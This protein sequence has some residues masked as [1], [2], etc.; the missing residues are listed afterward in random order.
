MKIRILL[1]SLLTLIVIVV[2]SALLIPGLALKM[3]INYPKFTHEKILSDSSM[4][5]DYGIGN[6]SAPEDYG[7]SAEE[8]DFFSMDSTALNGWYIEASQPGK[9]C[10]VLI[11]GRTSNR[12]KTMKFL[13]L[14]DTF[15]LDRSYSIFIPDLRNSGKSADADTYMG[16]KF[17]EDVIASLLMLHEQKAQDTVVLYGFSMGAMA[18]AN[19]LGR[20]ELASTMA[21]NGLVVSKV[22]LDSPLANVEATLRSQSSQVFMG[23]MFYPKIFRKYSES[24]SGFGDQMR[25]SILLPRNLPTLILQSK[26]DK[27]TP[28]QI[29]DSELNEMTDFNHLSVTYF[30]GPGHVRAFQDSTTKPLY[31]EAVKSFMFPPASDDRQVSSAAT[32]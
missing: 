20:E 11:H 25:I 1:F 23:K 16:Y 12:L 31:I 4:R 26:D 7:F 6:C 13:A 22:I 9:K 14:V 30:E 32:D 2:I 10:L 17:A 24:I 27:L 29:L 28:Y 3:I 15:D 21:E 19:A 8:I 5:A 18:I